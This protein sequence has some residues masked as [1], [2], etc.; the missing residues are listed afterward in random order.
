MPMP[1]YLKVEAF[2]EAVVSAIGAA[3]ERSCKSLG[4]AEHAHQMTRLVVMSKI[5]AA[6]N[7][8]ERDADILYET[9][10][11]WRDAVKGH[12]DLETTI[13]EFRCP[14]A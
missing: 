5:I 6:A 3:F 2:D 12:A 13:R 4:L 11:K 10:L 1:A 7:A 9:V 14:A 8:G